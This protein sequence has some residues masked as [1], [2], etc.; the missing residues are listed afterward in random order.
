MRTSLLGAKNMNHELPDAKSDDRVNK[1]ARVAVELLLT[2]VPFIVYI[3]VLSFR[4][5]MSHLLFIPEWSIAGSVLVAQ[6]LIKFEDF[7][8]YKRV[9]L[10]R[11]RLVELIL[12]ILFG[13]NLVMLTLVILAGESGIGLVITKLVFFAL[14]VLAYIHL[15]LTCVRPQLDETMPGT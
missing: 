5:N 11:V 6:G 9:H 15:G 14:G 7:V 8:H 4:G 12:V 1:I 13:L 2:L 10:I 3:V